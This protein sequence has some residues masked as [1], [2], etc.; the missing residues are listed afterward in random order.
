[1]FIASYP[2]SDRL[3]VLNEPNPK[4]GL[5]RRLMKR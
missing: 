1:M 3:A 2:L 5:V 4:P